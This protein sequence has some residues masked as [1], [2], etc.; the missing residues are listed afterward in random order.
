MAPA[1]K[2]SDFIENLDTEIEINLDENNSFKQ[3]EIGDDNEAFITTRKV[4]NR[5]S[6]RQKGKTKEITA[7]NATLRKGSRKRIPRAEPKY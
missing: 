4:G 1:F 3:T 6:S 2:D 7:S 5:K